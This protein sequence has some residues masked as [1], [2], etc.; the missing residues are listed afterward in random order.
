V[1][2]AMAIPFA[3]ASCALRVSFGWNSQS[4]DADAAIASLLKLW[5][6]KSATTV[7]AA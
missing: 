1:L 2:A 5:Q 4:A 6:R 3:Q 7:R